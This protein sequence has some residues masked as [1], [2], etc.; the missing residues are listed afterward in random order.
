MFVSDGEYDGFYGPNGFDSML[1]LGVSDGG[2][3]KIARGPDVFFIYKTT[4]CFNL[5]IPSEYGVP[6]IWFDIPIYIDNDV[7]L[8]S[9]VGELKENGYNGEQEENNVTK[10]ENNKIN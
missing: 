2:W 7:P 10:Q 5:D 8:S 4:G 9:L 3:Y 1:I 6:R